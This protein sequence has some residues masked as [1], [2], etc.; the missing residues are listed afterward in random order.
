VLL[1]F[2]PKNTAQELITKYWNFQA[3]AIQPKALLSALRDV[4]DMVF[5]D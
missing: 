2:S 4:K 5:S 3:P 1:Q